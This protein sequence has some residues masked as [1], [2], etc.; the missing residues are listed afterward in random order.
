MV[1]PSLEDIWVSTLL[2]SQ[3]FCLNSFKTNIWNQRGLALPPSCMT[4]SPILHLLYPLNCKRGI[5]VKGLLWRLIVRIKL[6]R[7]KSHW[8]CQVSC[9]MSPYERGPT[10]PRAVTRSFVLPSTTPGFPK[11]P[12]TVHHIPSLHRSTP[13][14][15]DASTVMLFVTFHIWFSG[16]GKWKVTAP[17]GKRGTLIWRVRFTLQMFP[18]N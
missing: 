11:A 4:L 7:F 8:K 18:F 2:F 16:L 13:C 12:G 1:E 14:C 5:T 6:R 9:I 3:L 15:T 10:P 17:E